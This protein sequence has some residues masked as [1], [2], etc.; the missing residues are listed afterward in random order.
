MGSLSIGV[1]R[2]QDD[3]N[4][5]DT[6]AARSLAVDGLKLAD[7]GR[8]ADAIDKLTRAEKLH[9]APIVL[10]RLGECQV[11]QG[12]IVEGTENLRK[13]LREALPANPSGALTRARDRAETVL[14]GAKSKIAK[15]VISVA[16][17]QGGSLSVTVDGQPVP[18]ALMDA[19]RPT[20]PGEHLV[21]ASAPG[22]LKAI[23]RVSLGPGE[24]EAVNL[25][26]EQD[27]NFVA[28]STATAAAPDSS[29][30]AVR[31]AP[32]PEPSAST[33]A[34]GS[35]ATPAPVPNRTGAYVSWAVGGAALV[36]G[37]AFGFVAMKGKS[38]LTSNCAGN[39][40]PAS[41]RDKLDSATQSGTIS[42]ILFAAGG[43]GIAL[44]TIL[45]LA[46]GSGSSMGAEPR[47][48]T[49]AQPG[50]KPR[51][52]VGPAQVGFGADF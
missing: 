5:A 37:A 24:K 36:A 46:A 6:A 48:S 38:D 14:D 49:R 19:E 32:G 4:S 8:C 31:S 41:Q 21:E 25:R 16:G 33:S 3:A 15:L 1:A 10:A 11:A 26:L 23:A 27:P 40:C 39:V 20:D 17:H 9:H 44:G 30:S 47:P 29:P 2:A 45:Y 52:W 13:V 18:A 42:T 51:A 7:A 34:S 12:R 35:M 22:F 28:P 43:A 50:F